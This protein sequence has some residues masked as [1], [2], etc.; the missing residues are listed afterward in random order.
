MSKMA[1]KVAVITG[2]ASGI[3]LA[4]AKKCASE[5]MKIVL[6]DIDK[7]SLISADIALQSAGV[8]TLAV[9][10]DVSKE[11]DLQKLAKITL[12]SFGEVHLLFNNA[13]VS[14]GGLLF[15]NSYADWQWVLGVNLWGLIYATQT[16][17]PIM[18]KQNN[19][20]HII[21]TSSIAGLTSAPG[22]SIYSVTKHGIV[23]FSETL[24]Y[25]LKLMDSQIDVSVVCP[26]FVRTELMNSER[27][28][29]EALR[30]KGIHTNEKLKHMF[31]EGVLNG[32]PPH[33]VA[34][35]VFEAIRNKKF[36]ILTHKDS[37]VLIKQRMEDILNENNPTMY[38]K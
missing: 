36:Y 6:A 26:G 19:E 28:R 25:E 2:A 17:L 31:Q 37:K 21:N 30:N 18:L 13:G 16:F 29:P 34:E 22:N 3:G 7:P 1:H 4:I 15:E 10:C 24:Y 5:G 35:E 8:E 32:M 12:E 11:E 14:A 9:E 27:N 20:C 23:N 38:F 33:Q